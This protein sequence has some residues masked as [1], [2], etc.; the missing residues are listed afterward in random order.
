MKHFILPTGFLFLLCTACGSGHTKTENGSEPDIL[1]LRPTAQDTSALLYLLDTV[2]GYKDS[3]QERPDALKPKSFLEALHPALPLLLGPAR[4]VG[5]YTF[6]PFKRIPEPIRKDILSIT[7]GPEVRTGYAILMRAQWQQLFDQQDQGITIGILD[8][9]PEK[10]I[11]GIYS[12]SD[13]LIGVDILATE[14][15]ITH[16]LRHKAQYE[17][18]RSVRTGSIA[19]IDQECFKRLST[20]FAEVDATN[21]ELPTWVGS[22][23]RVTFRADW[24]KNRDQVLAADRDPVSYPFA[25][26][27]STVLRYPASVSYA[28]TQ[29]TSCPADVTAF[30]QKVY[31][32][33]LQASEDL[34][35]F[36]SLAWSNRM[37]GFLSWKTYYK[38]CNADG[39]SVDGS[40]DESCRKDKATNEQ[41]IATIEEKFKGFDAALQPEV[42]SRTADLRVIYADAPLKKDLCR[43]M[44]GFSFYVECN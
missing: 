20:M 25:Q 9:K 7:N 3:S 2:D 43:E 4:A 26:E 38:S 34:G 15:T 36:S 35:S 14:G 6:L 11:S 16:E 28:V 8:T 18:I 42:D 44:P 19:G 33:M 17:T 39:T 12:E 37:P 13:H 24:W 41:S 31:E 30:A 40:K 29:T 23:T 1:N 5:S 10:R 22:M 27:F 32:R 21:R